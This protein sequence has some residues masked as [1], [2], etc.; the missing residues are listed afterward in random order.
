MSEFSYNPKEVS[1]L[2]NGFPLDGFKDEITFG[3]SDE[4]EVKEHVGLKGDM[5]Y[6]DNPN[7]GGTIEFNIKNENVQT[8]NF[9]EALR[10]TKAPFVAVFRDTSKS[11]LIISNPL[12]RLGKKFGTSRGTEGSATDYSIKIPEALPAAI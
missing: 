8:I 2:V 6:T 11:K 1:L 12:C 7:N 4:D 9:L 5:D 10:A 3:F